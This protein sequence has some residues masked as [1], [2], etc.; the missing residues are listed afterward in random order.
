MVSSGGIAGYSSGGGGLFCTVSRWREDQGR[1]IVIFFFAARAPKRELAI[2]CDGACRREDCRLGG[3][4]CKHHNWGPLELPNPCL[5]PIPC[6]SCPSCPSCPCEVRQKE[7]ALLLPS[8]PPCQSC[9]SCVPRR[10][11]GVPGRPSSCQLG[12]YTA[13][14]RWARWVALCPP[15]PSSSTPHLLL[16]SSSTRPVPDPA[17]PMC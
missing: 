4:T 5:V 6:P 7:P 16:P 14:C 11:K 17:W 3:M 15:P 13:A 1:D 9:Q 2:L 10:P 12:G 8:C